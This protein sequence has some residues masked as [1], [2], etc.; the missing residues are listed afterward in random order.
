MLSHLS[1]NEPLLKDSYS[2]SVVATELSRKCGLSA[3]TVVTLTS[4]GVVVARAQLATFLEWKHIRD[5]RLTDDDKNRTC[6]LTVDRLV[7]SHARRFMIHYCTILDNSCESFLLL[8]IYCVV[9][10]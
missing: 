7:F 1:D 5:V 2:V 3:D 10:T 4:A 8:A 9:V 6:V